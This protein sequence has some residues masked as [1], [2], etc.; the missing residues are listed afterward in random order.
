MPAAS[1][2]YLTIDQEKVVL[3]DGDAGRQGSFVQGR[4]TGMAED[5]GMIRLQVDAG[6]PL[7][8]SLP[9]E[10]YQR[11]PILVGASVTL[12]IPDSAVQCIADA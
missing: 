8:P 1:C 2:F 4:V 10:E 11:R 9:S 3:A 12:F 7:S 6:I 5:N